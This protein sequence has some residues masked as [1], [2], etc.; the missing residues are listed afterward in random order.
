MRGHVR[1]RGSKWSAVIDLG[2]DDAGKRKQK[3]LSGFDTEKEAQKAATEY[4]YKHD[5]GEILDTPDITVAQYLL[6]WVETHRPN[7]APKTY[8]SYKKEIENHI[9]PE[10]KKIK[11]DNLKPLHIQKYY[12]LKLKTLSP[13]TVNYQHR[14]I[15][16]A[17]KQ[18]VLWGMIGN[19]PADRV[20]PPKKANKTFDIA[21]LED[22]GKILEHAKSESREIYIPLLI[23]FYTGLRRGE[24]LGLTWANVDLVE[25]TIYVM[26]GRQ[27]VGSE[28]VTTG[29]KTAKSK[30]KVVLFDFVTQELKKE[31]LRQEEDF[32]EWGE[33]YK[34]TKDDFICRWDDGTPLRPE[35][36]SKKFKKI[37]ADLDI[38]DNM[39]FHDLRHSHATWLMK[40]GVHP[41]IVSERLGH[42]DIQT[43]M[44]IYSH[45]SIDMQRDAIRK[46]EIKDS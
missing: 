46:I 15:R 11:L 40:E 10:F 44:N 38:S 5:K 22:M 28:I 14:I 25:G 13:T 12:T 6:D 24:I 8:E 42:S 43:T 17:L 19:N 20:T 32:A 33:H 27:F 7:V 35:Y 3:W 26:Q 16:M 23:A 21:T 4:I 37:V 41:K 39:R 36:L 31:K 18:A 9:A 34:A 30:R 1:K 45:V 29:V 2:R